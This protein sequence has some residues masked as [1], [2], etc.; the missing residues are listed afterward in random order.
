YLKKYEQVIPGD[1][2]P[3]DSFAELYLRTGRFEKAINKYKEALEV[4]PDFGSEWRIAY[5]YAMQEDYQSSLNWIDQLITEAQTQ[6]RVRLGY[7]WKGF[8][9]YLSGNLKQALVDLDFSFEVSRKIKSR[10]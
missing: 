2:N 1:A 6:A 8:Y 10:A 5:I 3:Y 7:W 9:H 4:K